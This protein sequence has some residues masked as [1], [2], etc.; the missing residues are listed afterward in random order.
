MRTTSLGLSLVL[1]IA[2]SSAASAQTADPSL[3]DSI[4]ATS[5]QRIAS[6]S[7]RIAAPQG[8]PQD[9]AYALAE[10]AWA[11]EDQGQ[12][13]VAMKDIEEALRIDPG[14]AK[15]FRVRG[16]L[17]RR[18]GA[19]DL[20]LADFTKAIEI[21]P[22][23]AR[24]FDGRGNT[25][26][27]KR[28]FDRAIEDYNES[29][30]LD[31][32]RSISWSNRGTAFYFKREYNR[33]IAEYDE[34]IRLDPKNAKAF[35]NR[36]AALKKIGQNDRAIA[37]DSEAIRLD[38]TDP[39]FF[40][41]RGLSYNHNGDYDLAIADFD[42]AIRIKPRAAFH[43][44]RGDCYLAKH[45]YDR[46]IVDYNDALKLDPKF[47]H[48]FINRGNAYESKA[49]FERSIADFEQA[50]RLDSGDDRAARNLARVKQK[51][52][53]LALVDARVTPSF[54]CA[55][56]KRASEKA[57]CSDQELARLDREIDAAYQAALGRLEP[58][59]AAELR[60]E[61][62]AF[63]KTRERLFGRGD[64]QLKSNMESRL[65]GLRSIAASR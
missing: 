17:R 3:C 54:D 10:R 14:S 26:N 47:V 25:F 58:G 4:A 42:A 11:Y 65:S 23:L 41:N 31:P 46:A 64:Y 56:A 62:A 59:K 19:L 22:T 53:R 15:A 32:T 37:D 63:V 60:R 28:Q 55:T 61:Q 40:D 57:I 50:V 35:T 1:F 8:T 45:D 7:A 30:R 20:A 24:A 29:I 18:A 21:D 27:G 36:G 34:A 38:P 33:A 52:D 48:A 51:R 6:C 12:H 5:S 44:N 39:T 43:T 2:A 16:E 13:D 49:D 9:F